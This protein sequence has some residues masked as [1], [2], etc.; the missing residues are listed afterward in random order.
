MNANTTS[1]SRLRKSGLRRSLIGASAIGSMGAALQT[2]NAKI[3]YSGIQNISTT[4]A[5]VVDEPD[6]KPVTLSSQSNKGADF[7]LESLHSSKGNDWH[8]LSSYPR[9]DHFTPIVDASRSFFVGRLE[10]GDIID[11]QRVFADE[12]Y[13]VVEIKSTA[14]DSQWSDVNEGYFGYRFDALGWPPNYGWGRLTFS[15]DLK[16][17][18][19]VDWAY[20]DTGAP[21]QAGAGQ[22]PEP[23]TGLLLS[24]SLAFA[25]FWRRRSNTTD[26][27]R[28]IP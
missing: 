21:I 17:M 1:S 14:L 15:E 27:G 25:A 10:K 2:A 9:F 20:E 6:I 13:S 11:S 19:L 26:T 23:V 28:A 7:N 12:N 3:V 22:I 18:T 8:S 4:T 24:A 16:V 5:L